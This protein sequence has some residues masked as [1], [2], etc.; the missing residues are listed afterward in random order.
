MDLVV[1]CVS[2]LFVVPT[3]TAAVIFE[4]ERRR[5]WTIAVVAASMLVALILTS[6]H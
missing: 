4:D 3:L 2:A 1:I 5:S 6:V